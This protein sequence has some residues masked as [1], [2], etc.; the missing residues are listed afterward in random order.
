MS[1]PGK[2]PQFIVH[3][4]SPLNGGTPPELLREWFI[5]PRDSFYVRNHGNIPQIFA[6]SGC[7]AVG[8]F[9]I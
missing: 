8:Q 4:T 3:S 9:E 1:H 2:H 5:T 7:W 6:F